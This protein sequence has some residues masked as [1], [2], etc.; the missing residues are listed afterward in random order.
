M[1]PVRRFRLWR[2]RRAARRRLLE[3]LSAGIER[4]DI[5][6]ERCEITLRVREV[7]ARAL[8]DRRWDGA[9]KR[10]NRKVE[11]GNIWLGPT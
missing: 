2:E 8:W 11:Y 10:S 3:D 6:P 7:T 9:P 1:N 4:I 5:T